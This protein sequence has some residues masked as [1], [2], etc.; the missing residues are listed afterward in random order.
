MFLK[1]VFIHTLLVHRNVID[2]CVF[3]LYFK[4]KIKPLVSFKNVLAD[5]LNFPPDKP[6][7]N[8]NLFPRSGFFFPVQNIIFIE[9]KHG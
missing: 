8:L 1:S 6:V 4:S 5:L 9:K 3:T 2:I 7:G